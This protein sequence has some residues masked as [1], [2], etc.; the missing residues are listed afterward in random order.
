MIYMPCNNCRL[1]HNCEKQRRIKLALKK[2][3]NPK[4]N[5]SFS[6]KLS[7]ELSS[8]R[9]QCDQWKDDIKI[10]QKVY[11]KLPEMEQFNGEDGPYWVK[12]RDR[13][14]MAVPG[15]VIRHNKNS[16]FVVWFED[17]I[18]DEF[19]L[20]KG[21]LILPGKKILMVEF[22]KVETC[23]WCGRPVGSKSNAWYKPMFIDGKLCC[24]E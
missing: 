9:I 4:I 8:V 14:E 12:S 15:I 21:V 11:A 22:D 10:G 20:I 13:P 5:E 24:G 6:I 17:E 18:Q 23:P 1:N 16:K 7:R 19:N 3:F 2:E